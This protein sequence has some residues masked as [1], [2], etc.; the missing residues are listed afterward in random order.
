[1]E[2][3]YA[4]CTS[5][6]SLTHEFKDSL[7][8]IKF[9]DCN[10]QTTQESG[11]TVETVA[12]QLFSRVDPVAVAAKRKADA[13]EA[14][15]QKNNNLQIVFSVT[16]KRCMECHPC[17]YSSDAQLVVGDKTFVRHFSHWNEE[18]MKSALMV[19]AHDVL[20]LAK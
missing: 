2:K 9:T 6:Q 5:G 16:D 17:I 19:E 1:M 8:V 20:L 4:L 12:A 11:K 3:L 18:K 15:A 7:H 13:L 10:G 14:F